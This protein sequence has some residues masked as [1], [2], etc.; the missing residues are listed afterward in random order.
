MHRER[1]INI[2]GRHGSNNELTALLNNN[3]NNN[4]KMLSYRGETALQSA[5]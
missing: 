4:N 3:N 5:L 1:V 2:R